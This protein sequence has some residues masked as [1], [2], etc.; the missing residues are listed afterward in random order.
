MTPAVD[1]SGII[2][3]HEVTAVAGY[4]DDGIYCKLGEVIPFASVIASSFNE[5][6]AV[7]VS[8]PSLDDEYVG[9]AVIA[10]A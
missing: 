1:V 2:I 8:A 6:N 3:S 10:S 4:L 5:L 7:D 9:K